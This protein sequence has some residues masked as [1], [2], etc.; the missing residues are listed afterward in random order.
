MNSIALNFVPLLNQ[1]INATVYR[2]LVPDSSQTKNDQDFRAPLPAQIPDTEWSLYD[3][4]IIEKDG[5]EPYEFTYTQNPTF[6]LNL[7][8]QELLKTL[9]RQ[10]ETVNYYTSKGT[11]IQKNVHFITE[12]FDEGNTEIVVKPYY[13]RKK[14]QL[15]FLVAHKFSK[16]GEQPYNKQIQIKSLSLDKSGNSNIYYYR[17][18]KNRIVSFIKNTLSPILKSSDLTIKLAFSSLPAEKLSMKTYLVGRENT[19]KS[20]FMGIKTNGPY[21]Q[22]KDEVRYLF[23]FDE[24]T[25][26]LAREI[27]LGLNGKLFP[28]Q[29]SGLN[30]MF[31]IPIHK[32]IVEHLLVGTF[33]AEAMKNCEN[34]VRAIKI[35][36]PNCKLMI[37][38]IL[39]K[40]F[41]GVQAAFDAYGYLK[42]L[43]LQNDVYC[44]VATEDTFYKKDQLKWSVSN[45]GLQ[46]FSKLGGAPWLVQPAKTNCLIFGLG[47]VQERVDDRISRYSAYTVCLDSSGDFKYIKP[48]S[49][50]RNEATYLTGLQTKLR[51][52]LSSDFE[53]RYNTVVLHIP[54]RISFREIDV[55][56]SVVSEIREVDDLEIIAIKVNTIHNFLGF[57]SHNT[58]V[59]YESTYIQISNNDFL[60]WTDGLQYGKEALHKRVAEPLYVSFIASREQWA[61]KKE[62]LQDVLNLSGA[63]WRGFNSK[64]Q[65][66]SILYSKLVAGFMKDFSHLDNIGNISFVSAD[67]TAPWFL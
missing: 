28:S 15:G 42:L 26:S 40:G 50:S 11:I 14:K 52:V 59:P 54:Y 58:C 46:I 51:E 49:S 34:R 7:I 2:K 18:K 21:R 20:Q 35:S 47:S 23:V 36:Y 3:I 33:D 66:I 64:A 12:E 8:Y 65:P 38:A 13:L 56:K 6:S 55:V 67:S 29:F 31:K 16:K 53:D 44:Q 61:T 27:Y 37:V 39:P 30:Q 19:A 48:L 17:D 1:D 4:S 5:Y 9:E 32:D 25:R 43:A 63:N 10:N 60:V 22:I 57:S 45:I 62:C 41:K 24:R